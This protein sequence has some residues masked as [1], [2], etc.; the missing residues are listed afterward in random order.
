[1]TLPVTIAHRAGNSYERLDRALAAGVD[2]VEIDTR[3]D[4]GRFAGRHDGRLFFLPVYG[5]RWYVRFSLA[6]ATY[7]DEVLRRVAGRASLL[8]DVK[9]TGV[10]ALK[11][12]LDTLR[13]QNAIAGT[14]ISSG[15]WNLMR[16][17]RV[18]EPDLRV[19]YS[20]GKPEELRRFWQ[21]QEKT[22]EAKGVSIKERLLNKTLVDR[23]LAE[24]IE[25]AAYDVYDLRRAHELIAWGVAAIISGDLSLL[26]ALKEPSPD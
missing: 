5:G 13:A 23:F 26:R 14:R 3:L 18:S 21:L 1:M 11:L 4:H 6:R 7:L 19:Y 15:Y 16:I 24:G 20:M 22:H 17:A 25:I 2:A 8:V 10:R 9:T 12:L